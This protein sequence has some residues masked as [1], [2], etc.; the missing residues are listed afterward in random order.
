MQQNGEPQPMN[1]RLSKREKKELK[2]HQK[3]AVAM[4]LGDLD[5]PA[6]GPIGAAALAGAAGMHLLNNVDF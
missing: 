3:R 6:K 2:K 1:R 5:R 4:G